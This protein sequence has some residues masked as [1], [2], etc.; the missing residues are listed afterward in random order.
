MAVIFNTFRISCAPFCGWEISFW[1]TCCSFKGNSL[2]VSAFKIFLC[3]CTLQFHFDLPMMNLLLFT[4]LKI[5]FASQTVYYFLQFWKI[6]SC[7]LLVPLP[8][9]IR[10]PGVNSDLPV[11]TLLGQHMQPDSLCVGWEQRRSDAM[12]GECSSLSSGNNVHTISMTLPN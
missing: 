8:W 7:Y 3:F 10:E 11:G 2:S 4:L 9:S 6:L 5:V 12:L 1:S